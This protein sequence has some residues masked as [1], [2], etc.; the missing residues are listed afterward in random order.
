[1]KMENIVMTLDAGGTN[2]V[3]SAISNCQE[4]IEPYTIKAEVDDLDGCLLSI[5]NGFEVIKQ[6]L[7]CEPTAI[8]FAFPGP[9]DYSHGVIGDLPNFPAFRGGVALAPYLEQIFG[10]PV[11]INNDGTLYAYGEAMH[12]AL[13]E[14]NGRLEQRGIARRYKNLC[15]FTFGTGFG[16]G[17]VID[18]RLISGDNDCGGWIWASRNK[19]SPSMIADEGVSARAIVHTYCELTS[20]SRV[21][22]TAKDI[23]DI[24]EETAEGD[25]QAAKSSFERLA[26]IA[27]DAVAHYVSV[28][29]GVIVI[30]GGLIGAH[31]YILP[32]FVEE[33]NSSLS[34]LSGEEF[35]RVTPMVY[36]LEDPDQYEEFMSSDYVQ[37]P[38]KGGGIALYNNSPK[39]G[40]VIS[41]I[42]T[43]RAIALGAYAYALSK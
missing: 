1:M 41:H 21:D 15:G 3:F 19:L 40:V 30:G 33:L 20:D 32:K 10:I 13:P 28:V 39:I 12:G 5:S 8:S 17:A 37:I 6:R 25:A 29:D 22:L 38:I 9:A 18:G 31:K 34:N 16:A 14:I 27:A 35:R 23:F 36:N 24:A 4:I 26:E 2:F 43:S 11:Y 7:S 42:G